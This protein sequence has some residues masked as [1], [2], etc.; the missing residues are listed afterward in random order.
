M[1]K[2]FLVS[3]FLFVCLGCANSHSS[4]FKS[5][6]KVEFINSNNEKITKHCTGYSIEDSYGNY[7]LDRAS[8]NCRGEQ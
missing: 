2:I 3:I 4:I 1:I 8:I 6:I 7:Y 5:S